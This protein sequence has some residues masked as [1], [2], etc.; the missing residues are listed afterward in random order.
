MMP[1]RSIV[2]VA[3]T[4]AI[5]V[6][7]VV[8][9][10]AGPD[11][12]SQASSPDRPNAAVLRATGPISAG[13]PGDSLEASGLVEFVPADS[14]DV[15]EFPVVSAESLVGTVAATDIGVGEVLTPAM[16]VVP[17][18]AVA[19][20]APRLRPGHTA[21]AV[22]VDA[23]RAVGGW[24]R[25]GDRVNILVPSTCAES[26]QIVDEPF[27]SGREVKCRRVRYLYQD[28][29][30]VAVGPNVATS[31]DDASSSLPEQ[32]AATVVLS[33]PP[34]AA[35]WVASY[36]NDLWFTLVPGQYQPRPIG[37]LPALIDRLPGEDD[38]LLRPDCGDPADPVPPSP[39]A[40]SALC[41][42]ARRPVAAP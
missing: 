36:D 11:R 19:G 12:G 28:V 37:P 25:P 39:D 10:A 15:P 14:A 20:L 9:T 2:I 6:A 8:W 40:G 16:F 32:G 7:I 1:R 23:T 41:G 17:S 38:A 3:A 30:V 22:T 26:G 21:L 31:G 5:V 33:L 29:L 35:Q 13:T 18:A 34:R 27:D 4:V 42:D 24:L